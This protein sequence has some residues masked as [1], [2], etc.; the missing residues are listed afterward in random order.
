MIK[1]IGIAVWAGTLILTGMFLAIGFW[2]GRKIT[3][4]LDLAI[5][6]RKLHQI[7]QALERE[8]ERELATN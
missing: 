4:R 2:L 8:L 3:E 5:G 1:F 7:E 6:V